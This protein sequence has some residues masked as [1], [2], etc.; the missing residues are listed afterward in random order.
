MR[1]PSTIL[2][3][4]VLQ[5]WNKYNYNFNHNYDYNNVNHNHNYY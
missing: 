1:I 5:I 3:I 2:E 4:K